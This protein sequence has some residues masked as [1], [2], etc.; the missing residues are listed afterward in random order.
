MGN[1]EFSPTCEAAASAQIRAH[2]EEIVE[3]V[4]EFL[5]GESAVKALEPL[6][7][8]SLGATLK[9][10]LAYDGECL[11]VRATRGDLGDAPADAIDVPEPLKRDVDAAL[12]DLP[13]WDVPL[14]DLSEVR[15]YVGTSEEQ[16]K[17]LKDY[18]AEVEAAIGTEFIRVEVLTPT[19]IV[20]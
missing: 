15:G 12:A 20:P 1:L 6:W 13:T 16:I 5:G 8:R 9:P 7:P 11:L 4:T 10:E 19:T 3:R 2:L 18:A 17:R 14:T